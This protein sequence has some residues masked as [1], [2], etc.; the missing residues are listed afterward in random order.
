[1]QGHP[2][3]GRA[4]QYA[5][6]VTVHELLAGELPFD[7][8]F[9]A[10]ILMAHTSAI[11]PLL[12]EVVPSIPQGVA[13]AV[14]QGLTKNPDDRYPD[15]RTFAQAVLDALDR[16]GITRL[17]IPV[18]GWWYARPK[19][20][21]S[22]NWWEVCQTPATVTLTRGEVYWLLA[23]RDA[24]DYQIASL[25]RSG[26]MTSLR[27]LDLEDSRITD[28][29]LG[30]LRAFPYITSLHLAQCKDITDRGL[31]AVAKLKRLRALLL[32]KCPGIGNAGMEHVAK[33]TGLRSLDLSGT[34]VTDGGLEALRS[35]HRLRNLYLV[36]LDG[37]SDAGME[38]LAVLPRLRRLLMGN[39]RRVTDR[40]LSAL[41]DLP[42]LRFLGLDGTSITDAGLTLLTRQA[43]LRGLDVRRCERVSTAGVES[44]RAAHPTCRVSGP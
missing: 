43:H 21:P 42:Q 17:R 6:A 12:N 36:G 3:D 29:S 13:E 35:L 20:D 25:A 39:C 1:V 33:L 16:S 5:L 8:P 23:R 28:L 11:P 19:E 22:A 9:R 32:S 34:R 10:A 14:R 26:R 31:A 38:K 40:G 24:T 4:D 2:F 41:V 27:T 44:F 30:W 7:A 37:L 18:P 15:C